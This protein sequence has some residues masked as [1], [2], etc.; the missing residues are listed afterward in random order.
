MEVMMINPG[1]SALDDVGMSEFYSK[2]L[3]IRVGIDISG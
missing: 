3:G 2:W 1:V